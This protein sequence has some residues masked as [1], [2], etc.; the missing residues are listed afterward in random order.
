MNRFTK[1][2]INSTLVL[3]HNSCLEVINYTPWSVV[4]IFI[5]ETLYFL[6]IKGFVIF[7]I[8]LKYITPTSLYIVQYLTLSWT[9][10][11]K[12]GKRND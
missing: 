9:I 2:I 1:I 4:W 8:L 6:F 12:L 10:Y 3:H 11:F 5:Y 7:L